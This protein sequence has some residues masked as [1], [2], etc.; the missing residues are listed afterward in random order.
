MAGNGR[1]GGVVTEAFIKSRLAEY[2]IR[3]ARKQ[4][5]TPALMQFILE[6]MSTRGRRRFID[7][8]ETHRKKHDGKEGQLKLEVDE[9]PGELA[10]SIVRLGAARQ[11]TLPMRGMTD[12]IAGVLRGNRQAGSG[13]ALRIPRRFEE[14]KRVFQLSDIDIEVLIFIYCRNQHDGFVRYLDDRSLR[15]FLKLISIGT[16]IPLYQ[17]KK[18]LATGGRLRR[19]GIV[20]QNDFQSC[21][22]GLKDSIIEWLAGL[23][24]G[25]LTL[26]FCRKD[27]GVVHDL[28]SF[29]IPEESVRVAS[30]L[31]SS[32]KPCN[33]LLHGQAG[34]GKT[35][36]A[37]ALVAQAGEQA[38]I[39]RFGD[40]DQPHSDR[41]MAIEGAV[42]SIDPKQG[43]LIVDEADRFLNTRYFTMGSG[44]AEDKGWVNDFLDKS[45]HR[46]IWIAN[47]TAYMEESTLRRFSYSLRFHRF[48]RR[49]RENIW[50]NLTRK[51]PLRRTFTADLVR[52]LTV[53]FETN[54]AGIASALDSIKSIVSPAE[55]TPELVRNTLAE[56][57]T[58]HLEATGQ[59]EKSSLNSLTD[60]YDLDALNMDA[61][62]AGLIGSLKAFAAGLEDRKKTDAGHVNLLFWGPPGTGK[63][64]F[65]KYL[66]GELSMGLVVKRASDLLSMWV[67]GTEH[68]IRDAF[69][70]AEKD[71]AI[72]FIDEA[73]SFFT[74]RETATR[75]WEVTQTNELLT[76]MENHKGILICCTNMLEHLDHAVVRRFAWKVE[77]K[78]L[79]NEGKTTLFRKY[80]PGDGRPLSAGCAGQLEA[81]PA[82]TPGD[83]RAIWDKYRFVPGGQKN[84]A[85]MIEELRKEAAYRQGLRPAIGFVRSGE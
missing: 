35:Q 9:D 12:A 10:R 60:R 57:L 85:A 80:F 71:R 77:F 44:F 84:D 59:K 34:T 26:R 46:I 1:T 79:S 65:A 5:I 70:A 82:L 68:N 3:F 63:T 55:A 18:S 11:Y 2:A 15:A 21:S 83:I 78:P 47:E 48:S 45:T 6:L 49:E 66:A 52:E 24:L 56:L 22:L 53:K 32:G 73:D 42:G 20:T 54:A 28:G 16:G 30:S 76:Q 13:D 29:S 81:I 19:T 40:E 14:V 8:L 31:L 39:V 41:R 62:P 4:D 72:L 61:D 69:E 27:N 38:F 51:H 37:R 7:F 64:E 67:G 50:H 43:I 75:S 58:R 74:N 33:I 17:V 36:F 25:P 23:I